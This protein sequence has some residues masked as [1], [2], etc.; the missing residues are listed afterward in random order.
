MGEYDDFFIKCWLCEGETYYIETTLY[1]MDPYFPA[2][3]S[4]RIYVEFAE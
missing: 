3:G 1:D 4:Y 2:T